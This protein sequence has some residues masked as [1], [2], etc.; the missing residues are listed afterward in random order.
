MLARL[1]VSPKG[2][3]DGEIGVEWIKIFDKQ[4]REKANGRTRLLLVDG[5]N[6]H[7]T[8]GLLDYARKHKILVLCYPAHGTHVYQGLDVVIFAVLKRY[9]SEE[10]DK[11]E[12]DHGDIV[13]KSNFLAVYGAAHIRALSHDL[14]KAAFRETGVWPY[15]RD[16]VTKEKLA[17]SLETAIEVTLPLVPPTPVRVVT[18]LIREATKSLEIVIEP[19]VDILE[20]ASNNATPARRQ[21]PMTQ[22]PIRKAISN[23]ESTNAGYLFD[24]AAIR[25]AMLPPTAT[26]IPILAK[27]KNGTRYPELL[28][29]EPET[30]RERLLQRALRKTEAREETARRHILQMQASTVLLQKYCDRVRSQ[31]ATV[32]K[33]K[34]KGKGKNKRLHGDGM[35]RL[36]T[37]DDFFFRVQ[38]AAEEQEK[39]AADKSARADQLTKYQDEMKEW[40]ARDDERK[41]RNKAK[42]EAWE[43]AKADWTAGKAFAKER[44]VQWTGGKKPVL[45]KL[46]NQEVRPK[47][48]KRVV[49]DEDEELSGWEDE[50]GEEEED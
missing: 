31:L 8:V 12:H 37:G 18:K 13:T 49:V 22:T 15:N 42:R 43:Q 40:R 3:T 10:R 29:V 7:Y 25:A 45:G 9:F 30:D 38:Q 26:T 24:P 14:V 6:S 50:D 47:A 46:E 17:P 36:L 19:E 32:E 44:G 23:L 20:S 33:K 28:N 27:P 5:H 2:W 21:K 1:G 48:P 35:P 39:A 4:T 41:L 11:R 16:V 34:G